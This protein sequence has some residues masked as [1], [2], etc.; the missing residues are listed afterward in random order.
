[1]KNEKNGWFK[2]GD[3]RVMGFNAMNN[4]L[5]GKNHRIYCEPENKHYTKTYDENEPLKDDRPLKIQKKFKVEARGGQI[6]ENDTES[7]E[8]NTESEEESEEEN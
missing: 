1:M 7:D 8:E 2:D 4:T 6:V 5:G 3:I